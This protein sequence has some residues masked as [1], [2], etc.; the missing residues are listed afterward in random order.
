MENYEKTHLRVRFFSFY[1]HICK[2]NRTF[3]PEIGK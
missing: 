2:K 3:A 1:L